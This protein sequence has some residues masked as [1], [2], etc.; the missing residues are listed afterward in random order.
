[1]TRYYDLVLG[2]IPLALIGITAALL[3]LGLT[4]TVATPI[5]AVV[6][7]GLIGHAMFVRS[8]VPRPEDIASGVQS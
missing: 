7:I 3:A 2:A 6:S 8:P 1:M 5:A 4:V